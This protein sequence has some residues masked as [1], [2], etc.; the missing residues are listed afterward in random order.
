MFSPNCESQQLH[1]LGRISSLHLTSTNSTFPLHISTTGQNHELY[2]TYPTQI[3]YYSPSYCQL[4]SPKY[5][6]SKNREGTLPFTHDAMLQSFMPL[7]LDFVVF[8]RGKSLVTP[9]AST[10]GISYRPGSL[11]PNGIAT[12]WNVF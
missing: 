12:V 9:H 8:G 10:I 2:I 3:G 6:I 4:V 1:G 11:L 5:A 7:V